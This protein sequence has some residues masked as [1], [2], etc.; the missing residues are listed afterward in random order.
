MAD[1][2]WTVE[3]HLADQPEASLALSERLVEVVSACGP[4]NNA[5]SKTTITFKVGERTDLDDEFT[6]W[7]REAYAVGNGE[8][9]D[10]RM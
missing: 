3:D 7:V 9:L 10:H 4:L 1:W 6:G 8:H 5:V 2:G